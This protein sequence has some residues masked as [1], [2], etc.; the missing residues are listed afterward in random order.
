MSKF[1]PRTSFKWIDPKQF[2]LNKYTS[3]SSKGCVLEIDLEY[4]KE[5]RELHNDYP[6]APDKIVIEKEIL[7]D[8]QLKIAD[9]YNIV[10][11]NV[12]KLMPKCFDTE[13][14]V[15]HNENFQLYLRL[16]LKLKKKYRML[17]FNQSQ[18]LNQY[19]EFKTQER[20][21]AEKNGDK[22]GKALYKLMNNVVYGK[23]MENLRNRIDVKLVSNKKD[24]LK[25]TS[26]PSYM[27]H[28]IFDNDL[29]AIRKNKVTLTRNKPAYTG[30]CILELSKVLM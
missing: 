8:Y 23:T 13:K 17:E 10:I 16:T 28:K 6:L 11:S 29:V 3:N 26:K 21:E 30:M 25:W 20:I 1:L 2:D 18:L 15:I 22:D 5:L 4:P 24:Y 12:K 27:S 9:L 14:Y 19:V 7:S